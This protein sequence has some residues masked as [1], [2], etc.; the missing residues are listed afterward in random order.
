MTHEP[1][2]QR[3]QSIHT[4]TVK[5]RFMTPVLPQSLEIEQE[6][7]AYVNEHGQTIK[8]RKKPGRKPNPAP[9]A[10]RREQNRAAQRAFRERR[11]HEEK[12]IRELENTIRTLREQRN[13]AI[14]ELGQQKK[15]NDAT[16]VKNWYLTGLVLTFHFIYMYNNI[17]IPAHTPYLSKENQ[18]EIAKVS[19]C[20]IKTYLDVVRR[21]NASLDSAVADDFFDDPE[22][23]LSSREQIPAQPCGNPNLSFVGTKSKEPMASE[24][25]RQITEF[26]NSGG[27]EKYEEKEKD[28]DEVGEV[29]EEGEGGIKP[30]L[31]GR[32]HIQ[33]IRLCLR[34]PT[35]LNV[36]DNPQIALQPTLLQLT[37]RHDPRIDLVIIKYLRDRMI[38]FS[39]L[40]DY[41]ELFELL[42]NKAFHKGGDPT[43]HRSFHIPIEYYQ[44]FWFVTGIHPNQINSSQELIELEPALTTF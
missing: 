27:P 24:L 2:S 31:S 30:T 13:R 34:L 18:D 3:T 16:K 39:D 17:P 20:A 44:K 36:I 32:S 38:I 15:A 19:P 22:E 1:P 42:L 11:E 37:T 4:P 10:L 8:I 9:P 43:V 40:V 41:D 23:S 26:P 35:F 6:S 33:L 12:H 5:V 14:K 7:R 28:E 21:N 29:W 25:N